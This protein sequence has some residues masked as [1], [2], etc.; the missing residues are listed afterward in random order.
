MKMSQNKHNIENPNQRCSFENLNIAS[1]PSYFL[2]SNRLPS[3]FEYPKSYILNAEKSTPL[4]T[5][6]VYL[7]DD[8]LIERL[9]GIRAR[10]PHHIKLVPFAFKEGTEELACFHA[11]QNEVFIIHDFS[12]TEDFM[13][14]KFSSFDSWYESEITQRVAS[15]QKLGSP[16]PALDPEKV[17]SL[18]QILNQIKNDKCYLRNIEYGVPRPSHPEGSIKRHIAQLEESLSRIEHLLIPEEIIKLKILIHVHDLFKAESKKGVA[19]LNPHS[20]ASLAKSFLEQFTDDQDM[21]NML[22]FHDALYSLWRRSNKTR[23]KPTENPN[24]YHQET[25]KRLET[26]ASLIKDQK[27]FLTFVIIDSLTP[28]KDYRPV[29]WGLKKLGDFMDVPETIWARYAHIQSGRGRS[30]S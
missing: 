2:P 13:G 16:L 30:S 27:L 20:H 12:R 18:S 17:T 8:L 10:Y 19:I 14:E 7:K 26:L 3:G 5:S 21:L 1:M 22:Q 24:D 15:R 6:W 23:F 4:E 9:D 11:P 25:T 29:T 28:G